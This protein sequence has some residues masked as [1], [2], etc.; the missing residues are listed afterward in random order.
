MPINAGNAIENVHYDVQNARNK[1]QIQEPRL[2]C[3]AYLY[4]EIQESR[5]IC[6]IRSIRGKGEAIVAW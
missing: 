1:S 2:I 4:F 3:K 6:R 5:F